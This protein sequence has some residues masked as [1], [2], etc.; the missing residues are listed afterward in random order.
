MKTLLPSKDSVI[1][2]MAPTKTSV[3]NCE[4]GTKTKVECMAATKET[5]W[6]RTREH[7]LTNDEV[8]GKKHEC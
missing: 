3:K 2:A 6:P 1:S 5:D 8:K 4:E 7:I